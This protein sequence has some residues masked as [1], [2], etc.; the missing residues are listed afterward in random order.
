MTNRQAR[1]AFTAGEVVSPLTGM[2]KVPKKTWT[3]VQWGPGDDDH[4]EL[5]SVLVYSASLGQPHRAL[6]VLSPTVKA[7]TP[8]RQT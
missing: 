6:H 1:Q 3:S 2:S 7:I 4:L 5:N 8:A